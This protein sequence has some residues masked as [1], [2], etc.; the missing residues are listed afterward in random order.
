MPLVVFVVLEACGPQLH[1]KAQGRTL[2]RH[3]EQQ[4]Q[5]ETAECENT[6]GKLAVPSQTQ[7]RSKGIFGCCGKAFRTW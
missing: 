1:T 5:R 6:R 7:M 3:T 2:S 4:P